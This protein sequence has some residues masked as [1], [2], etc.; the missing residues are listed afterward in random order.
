VHRLRTEVDTLR[1]KLSE[2][3]GLLRTKDSQLAGMAKRLALAA[4]STHGTQA[5]QVRP[6]GGAHAAADDTTSA[7][8]AIDTSESESTERELRASIAS[9]LVQLKEQRDANV[10]HA[11]ARV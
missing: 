8:G 6:A 1:K 4:H 3:V 10:R 7:A 5:A 11:R 2:Y 9:L